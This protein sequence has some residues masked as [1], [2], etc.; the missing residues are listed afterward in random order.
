M[1]TFFETTRL[2][3]REF[4]IQDFGAVHEYAK[5][6]DVVQYQ[7][8]GPNEEEDTQQFLDEAIAYAYENPRLT[9]EMC[10]VLKEHG[11][12]IGG[13]GL[14][15]ENEDLQEAKVG[16]IINPKY[17]NQGLATEAVQGLL[18]YAQHQLGINVIKATCDTRNKASQRV[19]EK[20]GFQL[21]KTIKDDYIQKGVIR[22]SYL[23]RF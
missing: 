6:K 11:K 15:I 13:C 14:Y 16:Y 8:W 12:A 5:E 21:E 9:Y 17:W 2:I 7:A 1:T 3:A 10:L 4:S 22:D 20:C 19:L 18:Q 23:Y